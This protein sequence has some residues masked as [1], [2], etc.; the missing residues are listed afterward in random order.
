MPQHKVHLLDIICQGCIILMVVA[1]VV[2]INLL[3]I[4]VTLQC[5]VSF[6][7]F[8]W[9]MSTASCHLMLVVNVND[10]PNYSIK[11]ILTLLDFSSLDG[12][13]CYTV[14]ATWEC[15]E[16]PACVTESLVVL[17]CL[18]LS[19]IWHTK[20]K[21]KSDWSVKTYIQADHN[22][23]RPIRRQCNVKV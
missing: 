8:H 15:L 7:P 3:L 1:R 10:T 18:E 4:C 20:V 22:T 6:Q 21:A 2:P 9:P 14:S 12:T 11:K 5:V 13:V 16:H 23:T 19:L 17:P